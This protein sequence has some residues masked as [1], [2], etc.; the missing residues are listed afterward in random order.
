MKTILNF[1]ESIAVAVKLLILLAIFLLIAWAFGREA[2]AAGLFFMS[3]PFLFGAALSTDRVTETKQR[4]AKSYP[5]KAATKIYAGAMVC[6]DG[7]GWALPAADA[8]NLKMVG[9]ATKQ[10]DNSAG[11][12][13]DLQVPV[14]SPIV[15]RY[16]A[17]SITQ[18]MVGT[19]MYV[20]DDNTFDD[21]LGTNG[22]KAGRLVEFISAT[23]GW[24]EIRESGQ[25]SVL[26]NAGGTYTAAE[27]SLI[28]DLK[29]KVN[30]LING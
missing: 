29:T 26:A 21:A 16:S 5:V 7:N 23:E 3:L 1:F 10:V 12:N 20:V 25:G 24:I 6:V 11:A 22:I 30:T 18:A 8:A 28:N 4:G 27:Q 17:S 19:M 14:E 2:Q 13:G 15:A 9:V